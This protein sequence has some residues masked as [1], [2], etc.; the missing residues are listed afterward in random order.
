M[1]VDEADCVAVTGSQNYIRPMVLLFHLHGHSKIHFIYPYMTPRCIRTC[2]LPTCYLVAVL[3]D[4]MTTVSS[5][6]PALGT[7]CEN[8]AG[9]FQVVADECQPRWRALTHNSLLTFTRG[10][11]TCSPG[12]WTNS[13]DV[14]LS[15]IS[16]IWHKRVTTFKTFLLSTAFLT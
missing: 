3:G 9:L 12:D 6:S 14:R 5:P 1:Y 7:V 10:Y 13:W 4:V 2:H 16:W 15:S 8:R 11:A